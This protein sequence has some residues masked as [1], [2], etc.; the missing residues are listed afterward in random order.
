MQTLKHKRRRSASASL[1]RVLSAVTPHGSPQPS[2]QVQGSMLIDDCIK[3][4]EENQG[5]QEEG[6][7]RIS[8]EKI[9]IDNISAKYAKGDKVNLTKLVEGKH[10]VVSGL[11]KQFLR[12]LKEPLLTFDLFD[13]W[14]AGY[15]AEGT[16]EQIKAL[17]NV[18]AKL[19]PWNRSILKRVLGYVYQVCLNSHVNK[20]E[21][22]NLAIVFAPTL[23]RSRT[24]DPMSVLND[25]R[26]ALV[27]FLIDHYTELFSDA[28]ESP[29]PP[30]VLQCTASAVLGEPLF[31]QQ[32]LDRLKEKVTQKRRRLADKSDG[33]ADVLATSQ[34]T[35]GCCSI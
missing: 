18:I 24:D 5:V 6:M 17:R 20:M 1:S 23:L 26:R 29:A 15:R 25:D 12:E 31:L 27:Q 11:L 13:S 9:I 32:E 8:G 33:E 7:F 22:N 10:H 16:E 28:P 21:S 14:M 30:V 34:D 2:V 19:P 3:W 4:L 35:T